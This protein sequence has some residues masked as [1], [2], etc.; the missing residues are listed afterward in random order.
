L[1]IDVRE[2]IKISQIHI[3]FRG[4]LIASSKIKRKPAASYYLLGKEMELTEMKY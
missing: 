1:L 4:K 2:S 3:E